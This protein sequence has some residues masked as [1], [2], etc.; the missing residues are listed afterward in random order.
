MQQR[1]P[2]TAD[3]RRMWKLQRAQQKK[4]RKVK[5]RSRKPEK[6]VRQQRAAVSPLRAAACRASSIRCSSLCLASCWKRS[7]VAASYLLATTIHEKKVKCFLLQDLQVCLLKRAAPTSTR[8]E[9]QVQTIQGG[10][11]SIVVE[12][13]PGDLQCQLP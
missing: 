11:H 12:V 13:L 6:R 7:S 1:L 9:Q 5:S 8:N 10:H 3:A 4:N 2:V